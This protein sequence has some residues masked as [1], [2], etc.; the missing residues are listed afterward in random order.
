[1][2]QMACAQGGLCQFDFAD[3]SHPEIIP[4]N[5]D[6]GAIPYDIAITETGGSHEDLTDEYA[7]VPLE[8]KGVAQMFGEEYLKNV[9]G[10][11]LLEKCRRKSGEKLGDRAFLRA[12]HFSK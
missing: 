11:M 1:M 6:L 8:M 9:T 12:V 5:V 4:V 3:P 10:D 2:D 7:A